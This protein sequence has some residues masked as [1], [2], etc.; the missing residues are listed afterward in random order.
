MP[1]FKISHKNP[2]T[3]ETAHVCVQFGNNLTDVSE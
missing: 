1:V 3:A 2:S